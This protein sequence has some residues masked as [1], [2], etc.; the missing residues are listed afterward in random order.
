MSD[1]EWG[2][3][4]D[5][6]EATIN[7]E[8]YDEEPQSRIEELLLELKQV[9][10]QGGGGGGGTYTESVLFENT[11]TTNPDTITLDDSIF[12]YDV[13]V[14][15]AVRTFDGDVNSVINVFY[16]TS[17]LGVNYIVNILGWEGNN[18]FILYTITDNTT[19]SLSNQGGYLY[20]DKIIGI[21]HGTN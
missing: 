19:L 12:D 14:I 16:L 20:V 4:A 9:I 6:L 8:P 2:R 13:I 5:I 21:K 7:G 15:H 1:V 11:G 10:E 18:E 3:N 17:L